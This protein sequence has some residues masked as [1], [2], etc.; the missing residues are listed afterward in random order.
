MFDDGPKNVPKL[1]TCVINCVV[2]DGTPVDTCINTRLVI[3]RRLYAIQ[4]DKVHQNYRL[5]VA[6]YVGL[7]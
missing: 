7:C 2:H 6:A 1:V 4:N 5:D 3:E